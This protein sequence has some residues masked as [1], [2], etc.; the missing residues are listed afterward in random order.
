MKIL[1]CSHLSG[2]ESYVDCV[3][4]RSYMESQTCTAVYC[5]AYT[6]SPSASDREYGYA[7]QKSKWNDTRQQQLWAIKRPIARTTTQTQ[8]PYT[9]NHANDLER[10]SAFQSVVNNANDKRQLVVYGRWFSVAWHRRMCRDL[11]SRRTDGEFIGNWEQIER[12]GMTRTQQDN[13]AEVHCKA[14]TQFKCFLPHMCVRSPQY[15]S[16]SKH[17]VVRVYILNQNLKL[18]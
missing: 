12:N 14:I 13:V 10:L 11:S 17:H 18:I 3:F 4:V 1:N 9:F 8:H 15:T 7:G 5:T 6:R 2:L 16:N